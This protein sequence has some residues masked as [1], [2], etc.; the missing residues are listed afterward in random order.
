M[1]RLAAVVVSWMLGI[2]V[3]AP[4]MAQET[5]PGP[6]WWPGDRA[7]M[8][9]HAFAL[10]VPDGWVALDLT[11]GLPRQVS[12]V[13]DAVGM[14]DD[15]AER[16]V[17]ALRRTRDRGALLVLSTDDANCEVRV[18]PAPGPGYSEALARFRYQDLLDDDDILSVDQPRPVALPSGPAFVM[19]WTT[20]GANPEMSMYL[21]QR[22]DASGQG[23]DLAFEVKCSGQPRP[24][25]DWFSVAQAFEWLSAAGSADPGGGADE[26]SPAPAGASEVPAGPPYPDRVEGTGVYDQAGVFGPF[27]IGVA[28]QVIR[29]V[30]EDSGA[31][32]V[33]YTQVKPESDTFEEAE[34]DAAALTDQ[35]SLEPDSLVILFD[36]DP[37]LCYGQVQLYASAGY[38]ARH[39]STAERQALFDEAIVPPL[40]E[41]DFDTALLG[42]MSRISQA[43]ADV[44]SPTGPQA[45]DPTTVTPSMAADDLFPRQLRDGALTAR[46]VAIYRGEQD[47]L[48]FFFD[49][50]P[51]ASGSEAIREVAERAGGSVDD[52]TIVDAWFDTEDGTSVVNLGAFQVRGADT[53]ELRGSMHALAMAM[54]GDPGSVEEEIAG[55]Q[56]TVYDTMESLERMNYLYVHDDIAWVFATFEEYAAVVLA[57]LPG[58]SIP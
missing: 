37:G 9:Q 6:P 54:M 18:D 44:P 38:A 57:S 36:L 47:V 26:A 46:D 32:V 53:D 39:L 28:E 41:C 43:A 49:E 31:Q 8:A 15:A 11:A 12:A 7:E 33:V 29:E 13:A 25:D 52:M 22:D 55:K 17:Q 20:E 3:T 30:A 16:Y 14:S 19:T 5:S 56:V 51:D 58:A 2:V 4:V 21:G 45:G 27:A 34:A 23:D 40:R 35:W 50:E 10:M 42:A 48:G 1:R 24:G